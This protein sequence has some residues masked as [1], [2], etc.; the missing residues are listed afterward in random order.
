[1]ISKV[2]GNFV[3]DP[4]EVRTDAMARSVEEIQAFL[5]QVLARQNINGKATGSLGEDCHI[6]SNGSLQDKSE[7]SLLKLGG[8]TEMESSRGVSGSIVVLTAGVTEV[9]GLGIDDRTASLLRLVVNDGTVRSS[10]GDGIK[11][12]TSEQLVLG[13]NLLELVSTVDF[14][15][16]GFLVDKLVFEPGKVLGQGGTVT[17][18]AS[19]HA[20][21]L[22]FVLDGLG[23]SD[24]T[25]SLLNLT[26][27]AETDTQSPRG[28]V[29]QQELLGVLARGLASNSESL[30]ISKDGIVRLDNH[31]LSKV[32]L[33]LRG[34]LIILDIN[35]SCGGRDQNV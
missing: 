1:M 31:V 24:G 19:A 13:A 17:D 5:P 27:A 3:K 22:G 21:K 2:P 35:L 20:L 14:I 8:G 15:K 28:F 4:Y 16:D 9:D 6:N 12:K 10:G 34:Q 23:I 32:S 26:F 30:G 25:P 29:G 18:V 7:S 11:R 33:D